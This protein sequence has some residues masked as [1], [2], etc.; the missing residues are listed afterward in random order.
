MDG[1]RLLTP[2]RF[3]LSHREYR[4]GREL[5][6]SERQRDTEIAG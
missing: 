5:S 6:G 3:P 1:E 4:V 2:F